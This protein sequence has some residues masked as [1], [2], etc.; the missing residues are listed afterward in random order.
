MKNNRP[1]LVTG[2]P[3]SGTTW[4]GRML[5]ANSQ[6]GYVLEPFNILLHGRGVLRVRPPYII[7]YISG[8]NEA[9]YRAPVGDMLAFR[10]QWR[11]GLRGPKA[12]YSWKKAARFPYE[13]ARN[14]LQNRRALIK[15]PSTIFSAEWLWRSFDMEVVI[16]IRHPASV[17]SSFRRLNWYFP[18]EHLLKQEELI[19]DKLEPFRSEIEFFA[20]RD[21]DRD[22]VEKAALLWKCVYYTVSRYRK[23]YSGWHFVRHEDLIKNPV[24]GF[25]Q[26]YE[27][28]GLDFTEDA[29]SIIEDKSIKSGG[30]ATPSTAPEPSSMAS[31]GADRAAKWHSV[32]SRRD[33]ELIRNR[34]GN[35]FYDFYDESFW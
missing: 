30:A 4:T 17:V 18:F 12:W 13:F 23:T 29:E 1:I 31:N 7:T 11:D 24:A 21:G 3:R 10:Y 28:L 25:R 15:D 22:L 16:T 27:S 14:R 6:V 34:V 9:D 8:H 5:S 32:L 26:L 19:E 2:A 35:V 20:R 33:V